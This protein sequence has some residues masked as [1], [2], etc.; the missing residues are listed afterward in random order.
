LK[1]WDNCV[2]TFPDLIQE[3]GSPILQV[4]GFKT[5]PVPGAL[6]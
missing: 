3:L 5:F 4:S 1:V 2:L 6:F